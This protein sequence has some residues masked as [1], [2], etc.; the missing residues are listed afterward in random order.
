[1]RKFKTKEEA[2]N[3]FMSVSQ[4]SIKK[5]FAILNTSKSKL[6][7]LSI[8]ELN[9]I[10]N[11]IDDILTNHDSELHFSYKLGVDF[12]REEFINEEDYFL[13]FS[14]NATHFLLDIKKAIINE[15]SSKTEDKK[16][17][18]IY[19]LVNAIS[20]D[21]LRQKLTQELNEL[22]E[23]TG[24]FKIEKERL[25]E[26]EARFNS[27]KKELE[28]TKD[29]LD[30]FDKRSQIWLRI[31]GKESIASILGGFLL[32]IM[33]ISFIVAMFTGTEISNIVES[34][35]LLILGYFFGQSV[36]NDK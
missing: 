7:T 20:E 13:S 23:Q 29:K 35:F 22:R 26:E 10:K 3:Y 19:E 17:T 11:K 4:D 30:I 12:L 18:S 15:I 8:N 33:S 6:E 1:M 31:F 25:D 9:Q 14:Y 34:A 36:K 2:Q 21:D 28:L 5:K 32:L 16:I 27:E 24:E